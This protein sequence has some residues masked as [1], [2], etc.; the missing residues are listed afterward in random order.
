MAELILTEE[1]KAANSWLEVSDE[2]LGR[3][4]KASVLSIQAKATELN[5]L[6]MATCGF[7]LCN[8]ACDSNASHLTLD[9]DG[10]TLGDEQRGQWKITVEEV[11]GAIG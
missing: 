6:Y 9:V 5:K 8:L 7:M 1:E 2:A 4:I 3:M 10:L 11:T